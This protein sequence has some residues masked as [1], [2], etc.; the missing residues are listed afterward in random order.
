MSHSAVIAKD[1]V[2]SGQKL[3]LS[4]DMKQQ[5]ALLKKTQPGRARP[6]HPDL[7]IVTFDA[8]LE[9]AI[10]DPVVMWIKSTCC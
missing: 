5:I 2:K 8:D 9:A 10:P 3:R 7:K 6:S 4:D 1:L